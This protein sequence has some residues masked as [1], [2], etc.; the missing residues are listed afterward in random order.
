M[1]PSTRTA[2]DHVGVNHATR[3]SLSKE[4]Q[5]QAMVVAKYRDTSQPSRSYIYL[6]EFGIRFVWHIDGGI[7]RGVG[8]RPEHCQHDALGTSP[9]GKVVMRDRDL[10]QGVCQLP[11]E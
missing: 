8:K 5:S 1:R 4:W 10:C 2:N 9:L 7:D 6:H 3:E 11:K